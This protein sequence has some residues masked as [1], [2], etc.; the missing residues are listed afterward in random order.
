MPTLS[1]LLSGTS[2]LGGGG[3]NPSSIG[4]TPV[5]GPGFRAD[6]PENF[7]GTGVPTERGG[8]FGGFNSNIIF[9]PSVLSGGGASG[10]PPISLGGA[11]QPQPQQ[12]RP[13]APLQTPFPGLSGFARGGLPSLGGGLGLSGLLRLLQQMG[14]FR[15]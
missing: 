1:Q 7:A 4:P 2:A 14:E 6:L 15:I 5:S 10:K 8:S 12:L 3:F 13:T 9:D 11:S